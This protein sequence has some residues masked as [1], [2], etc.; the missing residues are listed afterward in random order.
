MYGERAAPGARS[1]QDAAVDARDVTETHLDA[2]VGGEAVQLVEQLEHS[3]LHLAV[4]AEVAV[5][6]LGADGVHLVDED[7]ARRL[8]I[9]LLRHIQPRQRCTLHRN[10][11]LGHV[12]R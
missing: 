5:E 11:H 3:A 7:D 4:A 12:F 2:V 8:C 1:R 9:A 10:L 6:A